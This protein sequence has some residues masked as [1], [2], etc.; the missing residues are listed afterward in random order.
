MLLNTTRRRATRTLSRRLGS[1]RM[2]PFA[3][4]LVVALIVLMVATATINSK[5]TR[6]E[7]TQTMEHY[8][9]KALL[10]EEMHRTASSRAI[11]LSRLLMVGDPLM[12][13]DILETLYGALSSHLAARAELSE[14]T[15]EEDEKS[16]LEEAIAHVNIAGPVL[17]ESISLLAIGEVEAARKIWLAP[18]VVEAHSVA[19][20]KLVKLRELHDQK[21]REYIAKALERQAEAGSITIYIALVT[22]LLILSIVSRAIYLLKRAGDNLEQR[23][24][25]R[26]RELRH[27][28]HE[29][30]EAEKQLHHMAHH[31]TLTGLPNRFL[32]MQELRSRLSDVVRSD[33]DLALFFIDLDHFKRINDMHGHA[34][35][36]ALLKESASRLKAAL[37][38]HDVAAR[39]GGDE[40]TVII[41][42]Y[43][44]LH[45]VRQVASRLVTELSRPYQLL[46]LELSI[47]SSIGIACFPDSSIPVE[48]REESKGGSEQFLHIENALLRNADIA[49]YNAKQ[50]GRDQFRFFDEDI[51]AMLTRKMALMSAL[52]NALDRGE[53]RLVYQPQL[54]V[55]DNRIRG[56]EALLRWDWGEEVVSPDQFIPLLE[57]SGA[58]IEV[59]QWVLREATGQLKYWHQQGFSGMRVSINLSVRQFCSE[60]IVPLIAEM[61]DQVGIPPHAVELEITESLMM[62]STTSNIE[63]CNQLKNLGIR[64]AMD[65]F[66]TGYSS[67]GSLRAF[68]LNT[69]KIDK[70]FMRNIPYDPEDISLVRSIISISHDLGMIVLAEGVE[71][72]EQLEF[73]QEC[74]C[75][76]YQ[77]FY[78]S[79]PVSAEE[80]ERMLR[81][82]NRSVV[83]Q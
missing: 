77:G 57:E 33:S 39:L 18:G 14:I 67:L 58:I 26:T 69:N 48:E 38:E 11:L 79:E 8:D 16:V 36:D 61:L 45:E 28:I 76:E 46:D 23:V 80:I 31:D 60:D 37:R 32:F 2:L 70:I 6:E 25:E 47:S 83:N 13:E 24:E 35:G 34:Y 17:A 3:T 21:R 20:E 65:D 19:L 50:N 72:R 71:T 12:F 27:E 29:R 49:M 55:A 68:D 56:V 63:R 9:R 4:A 74:G 22:L 62:E 42:R 53:Y 73:L 52:R 43:S 30:R 66:G 51:G 7:I 82:Q 40:F 44:S 75:D 59:G 1:R 64:L 5:Q 78:F 54:S 10:A 81:E 15:V 41:S